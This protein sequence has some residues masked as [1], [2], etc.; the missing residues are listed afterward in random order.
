MAG[1][2]CLQLLESNIARYFAA[3][4]LGGITALPLQ[5]LDEALVQLFLRLRQL[6][7]SVV[8]SSN[9]DNVRLRAWQCFPGPPPFPPSALHSF[10]DVV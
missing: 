10:L 4:W 2:R 8:S 9:T 7:L 3:D 1:I 5:E 6:L